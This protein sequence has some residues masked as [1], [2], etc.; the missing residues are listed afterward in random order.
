VGYRLGARLT[1]MTA[2]IPRFIGPRR[3]ALEVGI[4]GLGVFTVAALVIPAT[5]LA[6]DAE[7]S[8]WMLG[9]RT[10]LLTNIALVFNS[11]GRG[12]GRALT[13]A[14]IALLIVFVL[15][16]WLALLAFALVETATPIISSIA[17]LLVARPRPPDP[18]VHP[19]GTSF[20]SGHAAYAGATCVAVVLLFSHPGTRRRLWWALAALLIL[21]M[22]WSRT[23][24]QVHW[25]SDALAGALLGV[26]VA[27]IV[28]AHAE[29]L[30]R[31]AARRARPEPDGLQPVRQRRG[32]AA[33]RL[34]S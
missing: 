29:Y 12:F 4:A 23:Y 3:R 20:P 10:S 15:R 9:I 13:I 21:G 11:L 7:W 28:F 8:E 27:L 34:V 5:P 17:K 26:S 16:S 19:T 33:L 24:L 2:G 25:L 30:A 32:G 6:A 22:A 31:R 18:L 14:L 1:R